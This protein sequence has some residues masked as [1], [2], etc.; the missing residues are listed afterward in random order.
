MDDPNSYIIPKIKFGYGSLIDS[1]IENPFSEDDQERRLIFQRLIGTIY[2]FAGDCAFMMR[3][4]LG[5]KKT[6]KEQSKRLQAEL[7]EIGNLLRKLIPK[8]ATKKVKSNQFIRF[9][10]SHPDVLISWVTDIEQSL[11]RHFDDI[12]EQKKYK[13]NKLIREEAVKRFITTDLGSFYDRMNGF[14]EVLYPSI[15]IKFTRTKEQTLKLITPAITKD[16]NRGDAIPYR[17]LNILSLL[18]ICDY[19]TLRNLYYGSD[20]IIIKRP[21]RSEYCTHTSTTYQRYNCYFG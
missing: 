11:E 1:R 13:K 16:N 6:I 20:G 9:F 4:E 5:D 17:A 3:W 19:E 8:E 14:F 15:G 21:R 12:K 18:T 7:K 10:I 2:L